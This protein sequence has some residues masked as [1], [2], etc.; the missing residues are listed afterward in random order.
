MTFRIAIIG[1]G[2][3]GVSLARLIQNDCTVEIFEKSRGV[4][5]RMSTRTSTPYIFD[6]G[7]QYF[8]IKN[9]HFLDFTSN[10]INENVIQPWTYKHAYFEGTKLMKLKSFTKV[11]KHYVGVPNM[12]SIVK[13]LSDGLNIKLHTNISK[14]EKKK[15]KWYLTDNENRTYGEFHW[16]ILTLPAE[17]SLALLSKK[18]SFYNIIKKIKMKGCFSLM[19]GMQEQLELDF[20][21]ASIKDY[22]IGWMAVNNSKPKRNCGFSLLVNSSYEYA[23]KNIN[24][25]K[26]EVLHNLLKKTAK[27]INRNLISCDLMLLHQWKF[28]ETFNKPLHNYFIDQ[29]QKIGV[30]GDWCLNSRVEDAF[31]SANK[32]SKAIKN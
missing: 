32:L 9:K 2:L 15:Q 14:I 5:G 18:V 28:V 6:H 29:N 19:L 13:Y 30:C 26:D 17:Q 10:L 11:H 27:L 12:D 8:M 31:I 4:G 20:D 21:A 7:A 1:S 22:D 23:E 25:Q 24:T 3:S 16:V